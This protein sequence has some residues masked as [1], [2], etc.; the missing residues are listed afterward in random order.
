MG[1]L[2]AITVNHS[3]ACIINISQ[4]G[5]ATQES[6]AWFLSHRKVVPLSKTILYVPMESPSVV[7]NILSDFLGKDA[8]I[9]IGSPAPIAAESLAAYANSLGFPS[10]FG[11]HLS[12]VGSPVRN[13]LLERDAFALFEWDQQGCIGL[14]I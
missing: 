5:H 7:G 13:Y 12:E 3:I 14:L 6:L 10:M 9:C 8:L 4:L 11:K 2:N 1:L